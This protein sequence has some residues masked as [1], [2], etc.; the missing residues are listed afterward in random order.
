MFQ[1]FV[2]GLTE[3]KKGKRDGETWVGRGE[4]WGGYIREI[5]GETEEGGCKENKDR[6]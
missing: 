5:K 6:Q 2:A 3:C 4:A 1:S